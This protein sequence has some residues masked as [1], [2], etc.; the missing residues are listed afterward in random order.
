MEFKPTQRQYDGFWNEWDLNYE[1][2]PSVPDVVG[3]DYDDDDNLLY[4][5]G[6][7]PANQRRDEPSVD[8]E[9]MGRRLTGCDLESLQP[10]DF[11]SGSLEDVL[12]LY[13][14]IHPPVAQSSQPELTAVEVQKVRKCKTALCSQNAAR[15]ADDRIA[16]KDLAVLVDGLVA[17]GTSQQLPSGWVD[18][19]P[20]CPKYVGSRLNGSAFKVVKVV[21]AGRDECVYSITD[22]QEKDY[23]LVVERASTVMMALCQRSAHT[24]DALAEYLCTWGMRLS[25]CKRLRSG[26]AG[27]RTI[28]RAT[29]RIPYRLKGFQLNMEDYQSYVGRRRQL[30]R[31]GEVVRAALKHGGVIWRLALEETEESYVTSGPTS[32]VTEVGDYHRTA[33]SDELWDE[34]LTEDQ[35][36][37]ICGA[38]KVERE[39][40]QGKKGERNDGRGR[41]TEHVSWFPKDASWRGCGMDVGFWSSDAETWYQRR[42]VRYL[43][44]EFKC[45]NQT[46]WKRSLK[47][48]RDAPKTSAALEK[49]SEE[50]LD[51]H[52]LRR[53]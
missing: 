8:T 32:R 23:E 35:I 5:D 29:E 33:D 40:G 46:E 14:G 34:K 17:R 18:L 36:D 28:V 13:H 39:E 21:L 6:E 52:V 27:S 41:L 19:N 42:V 10:I 11:S 1:F 9:S 51:R 4:T 31:S 12:W 22:G 53:T 15:D 25:T 37:M 16:E 43:G 24:L 38:Y 20:S 2:D 7:V 47:L 3:G 30:F 44:G 48:W 26:Q 49:A 45:E 50:F